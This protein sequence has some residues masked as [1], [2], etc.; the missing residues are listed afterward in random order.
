MGA[1]TSLVP[2]TAPASVVLFLYTNFSV[3]AS[4]EPKSKPLA[5]QLK[6]E[7]FV[8]YLGRLHTVAVH[9][10]VAFTSGALPTEPLFL[11]ARQWGSRLMLYLRL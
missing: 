11:P 8:K 1:T 7:T 3:V 5:T 9:F 2:L 6:A 10:P 4:P